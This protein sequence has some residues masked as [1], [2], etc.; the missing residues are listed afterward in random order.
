MYDDREYEKLLHKHGLKM[1]DLVDDLLLYEEL[2][3]EFPES[4]NW[5]RVLYDGTPDTYDTD[6][7]RYRPFLSHPEF[8]AYMKQVCKLAVEAGADW[9]HF[10]IVNQPAENFHPLAV[11]MFR[12]WLKHRYPTV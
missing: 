11:Q 3:A 4:K 9:I 5:H 8:I 6:G 7:Y 2:Y 12:D 1:G 10:D